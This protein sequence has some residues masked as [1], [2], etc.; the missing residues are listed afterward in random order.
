[1][2]LKLCNEYFT[3]R[4]G[5]DEAPIENEQVRLV[6]GRND[7][8]F[9]S[10]FVRPDDI[11]TVS[12]G[13]N[14]AFSRY[15]CYDNYRVEAA[16]EGE[17]I[18]IS[19]ILLGKVED[20][21][22]V[23]TSDILLRQD[24]IEVLRGA[25]QQVMIL[26]EVKPQ[27][28]PG[29]HTVFLRVYRSRG[30]VPEALC[31]EWQIPLCVYSYTMDAP[32]ERRFYLDLWQHCGN[33]ARK[34]D[35]KLYSDEHFAV[36][37]GY[38]K[39]LAALGQKAVTV[40]AS[41]IPW[42]GQRGYNVSSYPSDLYEYSM[43][44]VMKKDGV[45]RY[46]YTPMQRYI[47]LCFA[48]GIDKEIEVFGLINIWADD[49]RGFGK[50]AQDDPDAL[51]VRYYDADQRIYRYMESSDELAG[52]IAALEQYFIRTGQIE[53]VRIVADE[54]GD[55]E[56]YRAS[57]GRL[58][59]AAP[60]FRYKVAVNRIEFIEEFSDYI[61]DLVPTINFAAQKA[62]YLA[63]R[64]KKQKNRTLLYVCCGPD[65]PNHFLR[66]PGYE[67]EVIGVFC[68][69]VGVD[70]FLR[71]D[72]TVWPDKPRE[73]LS[74]RAPGWKAGDMC[75]VYPGSDGK[76]LLSLRWYHLKRGILHYELL[77]K[78][79]ESGKA[80][81]VNQAYALILRC[82]KPADFSVTSYGLR[83]SKLP[84]ELYSTDPTDYLRMRE[85][86]L[87]ALAEE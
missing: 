37:E 25:G 72:Y 21:A 33:I 13:A 29:M 1:M 23:L 52:Y 20:D 82:K 4:W 2:E 16:C 32:A 79:L 78:L 15:G 41:E 60:R 6:A 84:E 62:E 85:L 44:R 46:D 86:L 34:H 35:V 31:R 59:A 87:A 53:L 56:A 11:A 8:A 28:K 26:C 58:N 3:Y 76:P 10:L 68:R 18:E 64:A 40:I 43:I 36:L 48:N 22:G 80:N 49:A 77:S 57:L 7:E 5:T 38:V 67:A 50:A 47:D 69:Y 45:F 39:S 19:C 75:F 17:G 27:A 65:Y 9:C 66:S 71:W 61:A 63:A 74:F 30:F 70:G 51:R 14:P 55:I 81:V 24:Y 42:T 83:G 54:P 73:K 12:V